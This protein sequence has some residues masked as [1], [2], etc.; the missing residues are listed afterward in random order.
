MRISP[1]TSVTLADSLHR[2]QSSSRSLTAHSSSSSSKTTR[3]M[4]RSTS[5]ST[6][7][8]SPL[9]LVS[10]KT[11]LLAVDKGGVETLERLPRCY[12]RWVVRPLALY[13]YPDWHIS[14]TSRQIAFKAFLN[15]T[16]TLL[17]P[18]TQGPIREFS[19]VFDENP[20]TE[21]VELPE[22]ALPSSAINQQQQA[23]TGRPG[24]QPREGL[25]YSNVLCGVVRG[26]LEM[27][28]LLTITRCAPS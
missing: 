16:P 13:T 11:S 12:P 27:V 19:L 8:D 21:F 3:T 9:E 10:S 20:L 22:D 17:F 14:S 1:L 28:S 7:W 18:S 4:P 24:E 26:A 25:W 5:S 6:R 15:I 23:S 2:T